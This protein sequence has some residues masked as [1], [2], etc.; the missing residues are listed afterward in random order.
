MYYTHTQRTETQSFCVSIL[1]RSGPQFS[2]SPIVLSKKGSL[3]HFVSSFSS[4]FFLFDWTMPP[5]KNKQRETTITTT[6]ST[7]T[8]T[9]GAEEQKTYRKAI[10]RAQQ[11]KKGERVIDS[12]IILFPFFFFWERQQQ[13]ECLSF[14]CF[15]LKKMTFANMSTIFKCWKQICRPTKPHLCSS[16]SDSRYVCVCVCSSWSK[17]IYP[18]V[19]LFLSPPPPTHPL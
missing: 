10:W 14:V 7:H 9:P 17:Y 3:P 16:F 8:H 15:D 12:S 18:S 11:K 6:K 1:P 4:S 2:Q 5:K 13:V 19:P